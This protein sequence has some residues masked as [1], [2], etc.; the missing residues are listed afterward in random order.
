MFNSAK[1]TYRG[2]PYLVRQLTLGALGCGP[3]DACHLELEVNTSTVSEES[4]HLLSLSRTITL[5]SVGGSEELGTELKWSTLASVSGARAAGAFRRRRVRLSE[6][7]IAALE[8]RV[9]AVS[10]RGLQEKEN[11]VS[12]SLP[13]FFAYRRRCWSVYGD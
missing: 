7:G 10:K 9:D 4:D 3:G 6:R 8:K 1:A 5:G 2:V 12:T 13:F 11:K